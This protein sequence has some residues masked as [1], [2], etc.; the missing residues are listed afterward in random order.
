MQLIAGFAL[1]ALISTI[2]WRVRALS[3]SGAWVALVMGGLLFGLGGFPWAALL[4]TFFVSSSAF[5]RTFTRRKNLL[6][7]KFSKGS[8]R[9]WAQV[10][11][12]G[13]LGTVLVI[14][15]TLY[16]G[17]DEFWLAFVGA[18]AAVNADTWGTEL[19]VFSP[20]PPRLITNGR[21]VERGTSG[22]VS[23]LGYLAVMGGA[24]LVG[25]VAAL[26]TSGGNLLILLTGT[27]A[28]GLAGSSFDS[29]LGATFQ[30]IY[31]CSNCQKETERHPLH[32]CGSKTNRVRGLPW[33]NNDW[34]NLACSLVGAFTMLI[35]GGLFF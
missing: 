22:G 12:N 18:M 17:R 5:S 7:E 26:F 35:F 10:L 34:V 29:Y 8:Q 14:A 4:L 11:A 30:A 3:P 32:S 24:L 33:L 20:A 21:L 31:Y 13:G 27:V 25:T 15:Q 23:L 16:P 19:G 28:A 1:A 2:A 9:D 6:S